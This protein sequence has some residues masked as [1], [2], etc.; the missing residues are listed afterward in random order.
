MVDGQVVFSGHICPSCQLTSLSCHQ[1]MLCDGSAS[2]FTPSNVHAKVAGCLYDGK[3][4]TLMA[5]QP[6]SVGVSARDQDSVGYYFLSRA[7]DTTAATAIS[8]ALVTGLLYVSE[9]KECDNATVSMDF[10][11]W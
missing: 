10:A 8:L 6:F 1:A 9:S 11:P 7:T 3:T 5:T 4:L 2:D